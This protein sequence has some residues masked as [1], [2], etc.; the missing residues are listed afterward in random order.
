MCA[1]EADQARAWAARHLHGLVPIEDASPLAADASTRSFWRV[2][3]VA[4]RS[5]VVVFG[6]GWE[7]DY[8]S[9]PDNTWMELP[10]VV[11]GRMLQSIGV[12]VSAIICHD[13]ENDVVA[14]EDLGDTTM[15]G[16]LAAAGAAQREVL[17]DR[18]LAI[19]ARMQV[20]T[21]EAR[22]WAPPLAGRCLDRATLVW[23]F[24]HYLEWG[25]CGVPWSDG[26]LA[27]VHAAFGS[28]CDEL[29]ALDL[30]LTHR[31][32]HVHNLMCTV[33]GDL[34]VIDFQDML[35]ANPLYDLASLLYDSY[36]ADWID[37]HMRQRLLRRWQPRLP[38]V[39]S[40]KF[41]EFERLA[42]LQAVQRC[43]K[44][45]GRFGWLA[46]HR[47]RPLFLERQRPALEVAVKLMAQL[48]D[49]AQLAQHLAAHVPAFSAA[50]IRP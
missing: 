4:G 33:T 26:E 25:L 11:L 14:V 16:A 28:I 29:A 2:R 39:S 30:V 24:D 7:T 31:D 19:I 40:L 8:L 1:T 46:C 22:D 48:P 21:A 47:G 9:Q 45:A 18:A 35:L 17:F 44:A 10:F 49:L 15:A 50:L 12:P 42:M 6:T 43:L 37:D 23:E 41:P 38:A 20:M 27:T 32:F 34:A 36:A 3:G 5:V 13:A